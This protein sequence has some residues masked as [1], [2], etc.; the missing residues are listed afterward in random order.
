VQLGNVALR[1]APPVPLAP[2]PSEGDS[3]A[4]VEREGDSEA[5]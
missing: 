3:E 2:A 5:V 1:V 4:V